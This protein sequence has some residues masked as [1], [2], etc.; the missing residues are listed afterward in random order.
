[1]IFR[2]HI[3]ICKVWRHCAF[4]PQEFER[5]E[6]PATCT[7]TTVDIFPSVYEKFSDT[8]SAWTCIPGDWMQVKK[9]QKCGNH[10][11]QHL[12]LHFEREASGSYLSLAATFNKKLNILLQWESEQGKEWKLFSSLQN[13]LH[14]ISLNSIFQYHKVTITSSRN[15]QEEND[16]CFVLK[17]FDYECRFYA[18][19]QQNPAASEWHSLV[20]IQ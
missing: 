9:K 5:L 7:C 11:L 15:S 2:K 17:Y 4:L 16:Q 6:K 1:M 13:Q 14:Q 10:Q 8:A 18:V 12:S 3:S 20:V 19:D